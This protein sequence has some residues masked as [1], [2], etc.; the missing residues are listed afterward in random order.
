MTTVVFPLE[1]RGPKGVPRVHFLLKVDTD[2]KLS[3]DI[4]EQG[5]DNQMSQTDLLV[6]VIHPD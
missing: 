1:N 5:T 6:A 4:S 2:G 3:I